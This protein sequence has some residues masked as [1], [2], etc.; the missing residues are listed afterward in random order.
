[1]NKVA[2]ITGGRAGI[3]KACVEKF[4][5]QGYRVINLS[6]RPSDISGCV[7]IA[8]DFTRD[9]WQISVADQLLLLLQD[10]EQLTLIHNAGMHASDTAINVDAATMRDSLNVNVVAPALLNTLIA[11]YLNLGSSILYVGSTLSEKA[12]AGCVSYVTSKHAVIGLMRSTCQDLAGKGVHTACICPGFTDTEMLRHHV[13]GSDE[14]LKDIATLC[15]QNRLIQPSEIAET[16][17]FCATNA[18]INGTVL[19]ANLGQVER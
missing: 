14:V 15:T 19:H 4:V 9:D 8:A 12:V 6:R 2:I 13:G 11:P 18:V 16:L 7:D 3:G 5:G 17:Y 1:M 10:A